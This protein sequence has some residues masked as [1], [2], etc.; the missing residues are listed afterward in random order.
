M[1]ERGE[2][3]EAERWEATQAAEERYGLGEEFVTLELRRQPD[4][5]SNVV[6]GY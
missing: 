6:Q 3:G 1:L 2:C 5:L 4:E